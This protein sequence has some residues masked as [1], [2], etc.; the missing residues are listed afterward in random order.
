MQTAIC[1]CGEKRV[2]DACC[3]P[4]HVHL[5]K[6]ATPVQLLKAWYSAFV[7][8][9]P[10]VILE[11]MVNPAKSHFNEATVRFSPIV[12]DKIEVLSY[13]KLTDEAVQSSV[14]F[15]LT[16]RAN[17]ASTIQRQ[18]VEC[19]LFKKVRNRWYYS[20]ALRVSPA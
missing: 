6:G 16:Y 1:Y 10:H 4:F 7:L 3:K 15:R 17:E 5:N 11:T 2:Y 18:L 14:T 13:D 20:D 12:W 8:R 19:S 9:L